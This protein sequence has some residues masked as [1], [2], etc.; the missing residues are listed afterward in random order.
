M[1]E[2]I[3]G[4]EALGHILAGRGSVLYLACVL[5]LRVTYVK[6]H[7]P[8]H[9]K[10]LISCYRSYISIKLIFRI[11][12]QQS[13][14]IYLETKFKNKNVNQPKELERV[15]E[16]IQRNRKEENIINNKIIISINKNKSL[17]KY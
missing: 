15:T 8:V 5:S 3:V 7:Q 10:W 16:Q 11:V 14:T 13:S 1:S 9:I 4:K 6:G 12:W 2:K 17:R